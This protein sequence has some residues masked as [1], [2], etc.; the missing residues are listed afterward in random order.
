MA[1]IEF[2]KKDTPIHRLQPLTKLILLIASLVVMVAVDDLF[3]YVAWILM[4][5]VWWKVGKIELGRF[6]GLARLLTGTFLFLVVIQ[7]FMPPSSPEWKARLHTVLFSVGPYPF[8]LEGG[9]FGLTL[10]IRVLCVVAAIPIFT[11]TSPLAKI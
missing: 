6:A 10:V 7:G 2:V 11:M 4:L 1:A 9:L 8:W 3:L 5:L